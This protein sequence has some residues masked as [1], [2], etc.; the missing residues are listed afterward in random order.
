MN[1][2]AGVMALVLAEMVAGVL[3]LAWLSPLWHEVKHGFFKVTGSLVVVLGASMIA[4]T[5][6]GLVAGDPWGQASLWLAI[7]TTVIALVTLV[8]L[9]ARQDGGARV[10]GFL[11]VVASGALLVAMAGT[12]RDALPSAIFQMFAGAAFLGGVLDALLLGHWYLTDRNLTR[13]PINR[14]ANFLVIAVVLEAFSVVV[15]VGF[16][17]NSAS[18]VPASFNPILTFAGLANWISIGMVAVTGMVAVLARMALKGPRANAVQSATGFFYLAVV[19]AIAAELAT[20]ARFFP[21]E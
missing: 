4:S 9:F 19:T 5:N 11:S 16:D 14:F 3:W 2:P 15:L 1:G 21:L 20:K 13:E 8:L 10:F 7:A 12:G 17:A 18:S 6:A